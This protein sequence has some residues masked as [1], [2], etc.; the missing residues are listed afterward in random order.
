MS[1]MKKLLDQLRYSLTLGPLRHFLSDDIAADVVSPRG[2]QVLADP[3]KMARV[4]R[5]LE[6]YKRDRRQDVLAVDLEEEQ[7][8]EPRPP[9]NLKQLFYVSG[10]GWMR[11]NTFIYKLWRLSRKLKRK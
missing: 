9:R 11:W 5:A 4:Q 1:A 10:R 8:A 3:K 7:T 6:E 2:W